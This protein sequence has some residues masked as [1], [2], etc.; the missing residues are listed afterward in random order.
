MKK[1]KLMAACLAGALVMTSVIVPGQASVKAEGKSLT[2]G[3]V[4]SYDFNDGQIVNGV[5]GQGQAKA[6]VTGLKDYSGQPVFETGDKDKGQAI[7]L[8]DYGLQL[9][10]KNLGDNFTVSMW[11]KPDGVFDKNEAVLFLGYHSPE[12]WLAVAG[13]EPAGSATC[14]FWT[15]G[16]GNNQSF[17]WAGFGNFDIDASWHCLTVTGSNDGVTAYLDGKAVGSGGSI[18]A[19]TGDNQDIYLGVNNWDPEFKGLVDDVKVY[20][21]KL[22][23]SE[24]LQLYNPEI[25]AEDIFDQEGITATESINTLKG[26]TEQITVNIP[27]VAVEAGA[28]ATYESKDPEVAEVD[29][30]GVVTAKKAG[31]TTITTTVTLGKVKKTAETKVHVEAN[32]DSQLKASFDFEENLT[33]GAKGAEGK[34]KEASAIVTGLGSYNGKVAYKEGRTGKA[35]QLGDYGLKLNQ[36]NLGNDYTVSAWVKADAGLVENQVVMFLGYHNPENWTAISGR[37]YESDKCKVWAKGGIYGSHTTLFNPEIGRNEWHQITMTGTS[38]KVSV[39]LD[40]ICLGTADSNNPL[41]G[42]KQ[43]IYLGVN[44][45]D[46][47]YEGLMDDVKIYSVAMTEEEVQNQAAEEFSKKAQEALKRELTV[48]DIL[49]QNKSA[50]EIYYNLALPKDVEGIKLDW[51]SSNEDVV[52]ADGTISVPAKDTEVTVTAKIAGGVLTG[53][54]SFKVTVKAL[55]V[56]KLS[57]LIQKAKDMDQTGLSEV[58]KQRLAESIAAAEEAVKN[59]TYEGIEAAYDNLKRA[60]EDLSY[61]QVDNPF[62]LI[63]EPVAKVSLKEGETQ[64]LFVLPE[65]VK[66]LVTVTYESEDEKVVT[67]ADGTITAVGEGKAVVTAIVTANEDVPGYGGLVME[68]STAVEVTKDA[69]PAHV[70][71][72]KKTDRVEPTCTSEG[73]IEYW[74]CAD[75]GKYFRDA[76][77]TLEIS[78]EETVL[79][80]AEHEWEEDYTID[81]EATETEDGSKSI[82]CKNCTAKKDVQV[83][84]A[85]GK[86]GGGDNKPGTGEGQTGGST[87]N[88]GNAGSN[89]PGSTAGKPGTQAG[90][91]KTGDSANWMLW[92]ALIGASLAGGTVAV[93]KRK[94]N[95]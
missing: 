48:R 59:P 22:A 61:D 80:M 34:A 60:M 66:D 52:A 25:T 85:T 73:N 2:E 5:S 23:E 30:N 42:E 17:G 14:K 70:H 36:E 8:G 77:G 50:D 31:D 43:D 40:G 35:I 88:T 64:E 84:P 13:P 54:A 20:N 38:G 92:I 67:Y 63:A 4:A 89:K 15:N 57:E 55:D 7:R 10:Q 47:E 76:E 45:W 90:T 21:R 58:S 33:N 1:K 91:V 68:Y 78:K 86:P 82:H 37:A 94:T 18:A 93:R 29:E 72:L 27:A 12:K 16:S 65:A 62:D 53:E 69:P 44:N 87:G 41:A 81:K 83:I 32:L 24:V 74:Y 3:L 28:K 11:L 95:R 71:D 6:I 9:N 56:T 46:A 49:G 79:P 19:L 75:C 26:R 51:S 39:Y